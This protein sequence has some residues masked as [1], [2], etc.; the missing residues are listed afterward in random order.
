MA[1][2][3]EP[4]AY[5]DTSLYSHMCKIATNKNLTE[6]ICVQRCSGDEKKISPMFTIRTID[7]RQK[8]QTFVPQLPHM[9]AQM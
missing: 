1:L 3:H 7:R 9:T 8:L 4:I 5:C 6:I 2:F